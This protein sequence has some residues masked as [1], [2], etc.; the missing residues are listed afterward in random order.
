VRFAANDS[1][2][3]FSITTGTLSTDNGVRWS[4]IA[5]LTRLTILLTLLRSGLTSGGLKVYLPEK[6]AM[7]A[8]VGT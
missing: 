5:E 4:R 3:L 8:A 7:R 6:Q 2:R 1:H